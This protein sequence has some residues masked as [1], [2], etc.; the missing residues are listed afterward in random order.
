MQRKQGVYNSKVGRRPAYGINTLDLRRK[1]L[2]RKK[3]GKCT[4][5]NEHSAHLGC[6][7]DQTFVS[8]SDAFA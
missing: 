7:W 3:W 1:P 8:L 5:G 2:G 4:F 6:T